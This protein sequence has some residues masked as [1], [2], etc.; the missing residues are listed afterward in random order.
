MYFNFLYVLMDEDGELHYPKDET[1]REIGFSPG[2]ETAIRQSVMADLI[3]MADANFPLSPRFLQRL[4]RDAQA[5]E[6][7]ARGIQLDAMPTTGS[8]R[9]RRATEPL[10]EVEQI[11][12]DRKRRGKWEY[13]VQWRGYHP[14]WEAWRAVSTGAAG[15]P[16][17][18]WE[19][20]TELETTAALLAWKSA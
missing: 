17:A 9:K 10:W 12:A 20:R 19:P 15:E 14:S 5:A 7:E 18:T 13:L 16:L 8:K 6:M 4:G 3:N 2:E 1:R 11:L